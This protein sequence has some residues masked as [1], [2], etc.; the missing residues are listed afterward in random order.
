MTHNKGSLPF[1]C[2]CKTHDP[3]T[4]KAPS[5]WVEEAIKP[6]SWL[7]RYRGW[8]L[9]SKATTRRQQPEAGFPIG[10]ELG[11]RERFSSS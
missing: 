7:C 6:K 9:Q 1:I 2:C 5:C 3:A 11:T 4:R 10:S 8:K